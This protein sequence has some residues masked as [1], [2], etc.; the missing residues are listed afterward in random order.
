MSNQRLLFM[1]HSHE[2][3]RMFWTPECDRLSQAYGFTVDVPARDGDVTV[4]DWAKRANGCDGVITTWGSP[5]C[6]QAFLTQA[7]SVKIIGHAAGSVA[8]VTDASTYQMPI[9]VVTANLVMAQTVAE[10]SMLMTLIAQRRLL[11]YA[12]LRPGET[13]NWDLRFGFPDISQTV[14]GIWGM[15]DITKAFL[16]LL[17]PFGFKQ[18]LV[19]S[20][21]TPEKVINDMGAA[22][23]AGFE[24]LLRQSDILHCLAGMTPQN[25]RKL[26]RE[27]LSLLRDGSTLINA[28]RARLIDNEAL[29]QELAAKRISAI[30]DVFESEPLP[31]DSPWYQL[32]NLIM[33]PHAAGGSGQ[34]K[35]APY[36][37]GLFDRFF[38]GRTDFPQIDGK[39]FATMTNEK[40]G[41]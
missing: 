32:D 28:G 4:D 29:Q 7:P 26:D 10:W 37:L 24:E 17:Q 8:A 36:I 39:R 2:L 19:Y 34:H 21:H 22:K 30:L 33:T 11:S 40:C 31:P 35:Y 15:G 25:L 1:H 5:M 6:N 14:I 13:C 16:K 12:K 3:T 23:A 41:V 9:T 27:K 18:I 20:E 38:N